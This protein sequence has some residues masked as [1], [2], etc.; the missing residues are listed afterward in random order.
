MF[1][2]IR[3]SH[4][5]TDISHFS[6][7]HVCCKLFIAWM[8]MSSELGTRACISIPS[9]HPVLKAC[10][11]HRFQVLHLFRSFID[12]L[13]KLDIVVPGI[14]AAMAYLLQFEA[15]TASDIWVFTRVVE[16][17]MT[18]VLVKSREQTTLAACNS[19]ANFVWERMHETP[20]TCCTAS[21]IAEPPIMVKISIVIIH[22][23]TSTVGG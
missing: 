16:D 5:E 6:D 4:V 7:G 12:H 14:E 10:F 17:A 23:H 22:H 18:F 8:T 11:A 15:I 20:C 19:H 21:S 9:L 13:Y 3:Q 1:F 2:P